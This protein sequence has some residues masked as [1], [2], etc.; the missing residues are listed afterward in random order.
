MKIIF[1]FIGRKKRPISRKSYWIS[2][3]IWW[4]YTVIWFGILI[5]VWYAWNAPIWYKLGVN[6]ILIIG[7]PA[8]T[9]LIKPYGQYIKECEAQNK[10][11]KVLRSNS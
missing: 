11:S 8:L 6:F 1:P 3:V 5:L 9:D 2:N 4:T 7:T 10:E